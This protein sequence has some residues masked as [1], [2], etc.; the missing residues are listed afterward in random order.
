MGQGVGALKTGVGAGTPLWT[1]SHPMVLSMGLLDWK[2]NTL[3]TTPLRLTPSFP[4]CCIKKG[5]Q[6]SMQFNKLA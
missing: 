1:V 2:S 5:E 4:K 3:T 6:Y